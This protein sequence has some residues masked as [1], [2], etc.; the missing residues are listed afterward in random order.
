ME[1][2]EVMTSGKPSEISLLNP[3]VF[4]R[5]SRYYAD[6]RDVTMNTARKMLDLNVQRFLDWNVIQKTE[7]PPFLVMKE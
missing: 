3:D 4:R 6:S 2:K 7:E 1:W 5:I